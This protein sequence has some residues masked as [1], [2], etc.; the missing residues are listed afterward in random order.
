MKGCRFVSYNGL[1]AKVAKVVF[2]LPPSFLIRRYLALHG[3]E[4]FGV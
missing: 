3:S 1:L 4:E 2:I